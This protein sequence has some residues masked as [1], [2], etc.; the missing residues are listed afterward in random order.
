[1]FYDYDALGRATSV[2]KN[3][4]ATTGLANLTYAYT[5]FGSYLSGVVTNT[6]NDNSGYRSAATARP[7]RAPLGGRQQDAYSSVGSPGNRTALGEEDQHP[8]VLRAPSSTYSYLQSVSYSATDQLTQCSS[9]H[10]TIGDGITGGT[11]WN[12]LVLARGSTTSWAG[13]RTFLDKAIDEIT[14]LTDIGAPP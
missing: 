11:Y 6:P 8:R 10:S 2:W 7:G 1:M 12:Q 9:D 5:L 3:S 13:N 4:R 14:G